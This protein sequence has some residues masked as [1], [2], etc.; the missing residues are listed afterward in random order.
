MRDSKSRAKEK[1]AKDVEKEVEGEGNEKRE[2]ECVRIRRQVGKNNTEND[3][4]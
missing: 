3:E 2:R 4:Q 1:C